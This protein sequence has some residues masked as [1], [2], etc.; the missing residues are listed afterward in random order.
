MAPWRDDAGPVMTTGSNITRRPLFRGSGVSSRVRDAGQASNVRGRPAQRLE[1]TSS[2]PAGLP[3]RSGSRPQ[4]VVLV[5]P[6]LAQDLVAVAQVAAHLDRIGAVDREVE[7]GAPV[8]G[9]VVRH[10]LGRR[11]RR[12]RR[13]RPRAPARACTPKGSLA[14]GSPM[15]STMNL[16]TP[17]GRGWSRPGR[18]CRGGSRRSARAATDRARRPPNAGGSGIRS[19]AGARPAPPAPTWPRCCR[20]S[21]RRSGSRR[22]GSSPCPSRPA[23]R[24]RADGRRS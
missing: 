2:G 15:N 18:H 1:Q 19:L 5:E 13:A 4:R 12:T 23:A 9:H 11:C 24:P 8:A 22:A 20:G 16:R 6:G 7:L 21:R 17:L 10:R 3:G 14:S